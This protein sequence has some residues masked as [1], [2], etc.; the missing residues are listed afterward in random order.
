[1][2]QGRHTQPSAST[3]EGK[4]RQMSVSVDKG[5]RY[6]NKSRCYTDKDNEGGHEN[7]R[8]QQHE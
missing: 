1:M 8:A 7:E 3:D 4:H 2:N 5:R 6:T